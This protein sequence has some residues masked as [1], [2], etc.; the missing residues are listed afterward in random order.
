MEVAVMRVL[1][2]ND[3]SERSARVLPHAARLAG[4]LDAPLAVIRIVEHRE[5]PA[6]CERELRATC[7]TRVPAAKPVLATCGEGEGTADAIVRV[8][9]DLGAAILAMDSRGRGA[10]RNA[11][12]GSVTMGVISR[13]D[14]PV[15]VTA[16]R[17]VP[18]PPTGDYRLV[19]TDDGSPAALD[20]IRA[21]RPALETGRLPVSLVRFYEPRLADAGEVAELRRAREEV[22][23]T[24]HEVP[25]STLVD[26]LVDSR[27]ERGSP[28]VRRQ[29]GPRDARQ[30]H[31]SGHPCALFTL[32]DR[33]HSPGN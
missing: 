21:L 22:E 8:A 19:I 28:P 27:P 31:A 4:A 5:D 32:D 30:L 24:R 2:T 23:L 3:G 16:Q 26:C 29:R 6:A 13:S 25:A 33:A 11:L 18:E 12:L 9:E 17:A 20:V 1:A 10:V 7:S 15:L 14:L